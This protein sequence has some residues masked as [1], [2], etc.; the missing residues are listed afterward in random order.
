[1]K[2]LLLILLCLPF[3][4]FGQE[5]NVRV[6]AFEEFLENGEKI[7]F[8]A[9]CIKDSILY[10]N[11][12]YIVFYNNGNK[13]LVG[14]YIKGER[15]GYWKEYYEDGQLK[16]TMNLKSS[17]L[18]GLYEEYREDG[19]LLSTGW[20]LNN[21]RN[22]FWI[23]CWRS[24][25]HPENLQLIAE[26]GDPNALIHREGFYLNGSKEGWWDYYRNDIIDISKKF[27]RNNTIRGIRKYYKNGNIKE[28]ILIENFPTENWDD[29][30]NLIVI[31]T[32]FTTIEGFPSTRNLIGDQMLS[33]KCW[34]INGL[35][36]D[37]ITENDTSD[38]T[39]SKELPTIRFKVFFDNYGNI[40]SAGRYDYDEYKKY[41]LYDGW[42]DNE[43]QENINARVGTWREFYENGNLLYKGGI[44]NETQ[45]IIATNARVGIWREFY[46]NG[47]LFLIANYKYFEEGTGDLFIPGYYP[48]GLMTTYFENGK[49]YLQEMFQ[50]AKRIWYKEWNEDEQ[51][52]NFYNTTY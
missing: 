1:M 7:Y 37:C 16:R 52:I 9:E 22:G 36:I 40:S 11:G 46:K 26:T 50:N 25:T 21:K 4:G 31:D 6:C 8:E 19:K 35:E 48:D 29:I 49:I 27:E 51:L 45:E 39:I 30:T 47:N 43:T 34:D 15:S 17:D 24:A 13:K 10:S 44:D 33:K 3:M 41:N 38:F 5:N 20:Y 42:I 32:S 2:K 14:N 28:E 12:L 23:D 18:N